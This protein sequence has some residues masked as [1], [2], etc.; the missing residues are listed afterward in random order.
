MKNNFYRIRK[1]DPF[2][3]L[4]G[5]LLFRILQNNRYEFKSKITNNHLDSQGNCKSAFIST[6]I[7]S[8]LGAA[9]QACVRGKFNEKDRQPCVTIS[10]T[11][12]FFYEVKNLGFLVGVAKV[13]KKTNNLIFLNT[14]LY[15]E[16][17]KIAN[18]SGILKI[19]K[20]FI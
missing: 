15:F 13:K 4:N 10:L 17:K 12:N 3:N 6:L 5:K 18:A 11:I 7:D 9:A 20:K 14:N 1:Q 8:G 2:M 19:L 16:K